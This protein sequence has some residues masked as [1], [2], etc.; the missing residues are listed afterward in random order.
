M[1][2]HEN[3]IDRTLLELR[4]RANDLASQY[5]QNVLSNGRSWFLTILQYVVSQPSSTTVR[6]IDV[7]IIH[8]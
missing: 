6:H 7:S 4:T 2:K 1:S 3:K 8:K 5:W